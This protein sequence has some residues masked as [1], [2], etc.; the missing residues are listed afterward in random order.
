MKKFLLACMVALGMGA[1]AQISYTYGWDTTGMGSW[2][3]SGSGSFSNSATTPCNG[4]GSARAN[5]YYAGSSYLVS[6]ALTGTNGGDLTVGFS[7]KVTQFSSNTTGATSADFGLINL[8]WST[9]S[10]GPWTTAYTIDSN[11]HVVSASC[12]TKSAVIS[13]VPSSGDVY[14]RF[15]AKSALSTS[16][17]YVYFD[18]VTVS[19][20]AAPT[21]LPPTNPVASNITLTTADVSWTASTSVPGSGYEYYL[22]TSSTNPTAATPATGTS[23]STTKSLGS[24]AQNTVYYIWVRSVCTTVDKSAWSQAGSFVTGYCVPTGGSSST[25]YYLKTISTTGALSNLMYTA[26]SYSAYVNNSST[27]LSS[28][29]GGSFNYSLANSTSSTCYFYI[30][31]DWNN[32]LDFNDVGE[33]VL[34]TTT[35][36]A[37]NTGTMTIPAGQAL[38]SYRVR[39]GESESGAVT[40]CGPAPYGN[41][42]DFTLNVVAPPSCVAPTAV[43]VSNATTTQAEASWTAPAT[44]PAN[45]YELYYSTSAT[46]PTATT[47]PS[48]TNITGTSKV[49]TALAPST[50][51]YVWVRSKCSGTDQSAWAGP[52]LFSTAVTN[53]NCSTPVAL[54]V[55]STFDSNAITGTNSGSTTDETP[56]SCQTNAN[57]NVWYSVVVPASGNL[58]IE[59]KGVAGSGYSDSVINAF[60][61]SCGALTGAGCDDDN[62][63]ANFSKLV[64]TGLTPGSTLL[65][66]V[67]RW[68]NSSV[69]DGQFQVS[70]YDASIL[71]TNEV[72]DSKNNIKVYPNPFSDILNISDAANVKNVL[73]TDFSGRVVKTIPNPGSALQLGELKQGMYLVTLEMKDGSRQTI[74]TIKK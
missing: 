65:I 39:V 16:D 48:Y 22:S 38:G 73:V 9:S 67:W 55:G 43:T 54:T 72:K 51:Y 10:S 42:V 27:I 1:S 66:S 3:T 17:N 35:Y 64:L 69:V 24:L 63:D 70:A 6:P 8:Q 46:A 29:P 14:L 32:D 47:T 52:Y 57:N 4:A 11:S 61:G 15:E 56:L 21:C 33:E 18:D 7:Y 50:S 40:N 13:G 36:A 19:Q 30:W 74:K 26:N 68:S 12:A 20:G 71:A 37:T 59:T 5:N 25:S 60:T 45:G 31:V 23:A 58:T 34:A 49:M 28:F 2:T 44:V 62:G 53:D 41:Y